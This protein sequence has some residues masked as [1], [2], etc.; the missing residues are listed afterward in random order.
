[1]ARTKP[2]I[3]DAGSVSSPVVPPVRKP[4]MTRI[5]RVWATPPRIIKVVSD[6]VEF[7]LANFDSTLFFMVMKMMMMRTF[8]MGRALGSGA[9]W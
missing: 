5:H 1:M 4:E 7:T 2:T 9:L 8:M 3:L 6:V